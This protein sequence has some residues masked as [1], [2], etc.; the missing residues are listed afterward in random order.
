[1]KAIPIMNDIDFQICLDDQCKGSSFCQVGSG[2]AFLT[3]NGIMISDG[4]RHY[5]LKCTDIQ[6]I[7]WIENKRPRLEFVVEGG[8]VRLYGKCVD[9]LQ[10]LRHFFLPCRRA[11]QMGC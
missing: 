5:A 11:P 1:M 4:T 6:D 9:T 3:S 10:A 7:V 8:K 2:K